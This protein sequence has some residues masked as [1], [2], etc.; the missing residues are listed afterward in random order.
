MTTGH[1]SQ[2]TSTML[3]MG[4]SAGVA[5]LLL[6]FGIRSL[7]VFFSAPQQA[8]K[9]GLES[10]AAPGTQNAASGLQDASAGDGVQKAINHEHAEA[11]MA[12][13][14]AVSVFQV[15]APKKTDDFVVDYQVLR[16]REAGRKETIANVR[17]VSK[18]NPESGYALTDE[19]LRKLDKSGASFQ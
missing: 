4:V 3:I 9:A 2:A 6:G 17:E 19:Q 1:P 11:P 18:E 7:V 16:D 5:I 15:Q 10:A 12:A 14:A 8:G 13:P